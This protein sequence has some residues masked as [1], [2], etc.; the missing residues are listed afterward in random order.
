L[1]G[2]LTVLPFAIV[3]IAGP[4][5]I[6][7]VF[8]ATTDR[9]AANS[10]AFIAGAAVSILLVYSAAFFATNGAKGGSGDSGSSSKGHVIDAIILA[11]LL[12]L[13]VRT[14][15]GRHE[16]KPPKWMGRLQGAT[17]GFAFVLGFLLLG[18]FPT[19]IGTSVAV[20]MRMSREG[21]AWAHG[22]GFGGLALLLL[23]IPALLVLLLGKRAHTLLPKVREWMN[24]H[25]WVVSE[26]VIG[27]FI[28]IEVKSLLS[29]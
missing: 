22:L 9:W 8:L 14:Y 23:S 2:V 11:I 4:Q 3:M 7:A 29:G 17:P 19:D 25:A 27:I 15:L 12:F 13:A 10:F 24:S 28:V 20:G 5:V 21:D 18:V 16:S 26:F 6:S 1:N